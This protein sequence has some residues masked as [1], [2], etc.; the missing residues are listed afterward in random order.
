MGK[1]K[2]K[3]QEYKKGLEEELDRIRYDGFEDGIVRDILKSLG[4]IIDGEEAEVYLPPDPKY[5]VRL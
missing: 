1:T 2:T 5:I 3:L 4:Q